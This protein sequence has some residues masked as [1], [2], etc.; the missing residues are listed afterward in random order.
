MMIFFSKELKGK[1]YVDW[2]IPLPKGKYFK[3]TVGLYKEY[4]DTRTVEEPP[5]SPI[6]IAKK[7]DLQS[8]IKSIFEARMI[9]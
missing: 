3:V 8:C 1:R 4:L 7:E 9:L 2:Y 5:Y 6:R